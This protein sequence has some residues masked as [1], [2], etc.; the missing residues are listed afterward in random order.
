MLLMCIYS[1][2]VLTFKWKCVWTVH[3]HTQDTCHASMRACGSQILRAPPCEMNREPD[4]KAHH[5]AV[6]KAVAP[7]VAAAKVVAPKPAATSAS[8]AKAA[9]VPA[10]VMKKEQ[11]LQAQI[12][13]LKK[14]IA[15]EKA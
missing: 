6:Q 11:D 7:K 15:K 10:T 4:A 13:Q 5:V 2:V 12:A 3:A 1:N 8:K 14:S 9:A